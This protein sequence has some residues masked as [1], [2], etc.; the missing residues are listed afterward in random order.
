[1]VHF[2]F[3]S[4]GV[5][6]TFTAAFLSFLAGEGTLQSVST[7]SAAVPTSKFKSNGWATLGAPLVSISSWF[8][9]FTLVSKF[10][11]LQD[12]REGRTI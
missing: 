5:Q 4:F 7:S 1:V 12:A 10:E 11:E 9:S 3:G 2:L 6:V 8:D